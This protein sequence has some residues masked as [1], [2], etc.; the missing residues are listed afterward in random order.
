MICNQTKILS[1][2]ANER[3]EQ[4]MIVT[5]FRSNYKKGDVVVWYETPE[6]A[7]Y[8]LVTKIEKDGMKVKVFR[9]ENLTD[10]I[11]NLVYSGEEQRYAPTSVKFFTDEKIQNPFRLPVPLFRKIF[12]VKET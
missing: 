11:A 3:M 6:L 4:G 9:N 5:K 2:S 1:I 8:G 10:K 7:L 12:R